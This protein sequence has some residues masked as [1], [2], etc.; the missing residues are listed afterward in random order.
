MCCQQLLQSENL[1]RN[2]D[3]ELQQRANEYVQLLSSGNA[4]LVVRVL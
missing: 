3:S 1:L 4:D 2:S